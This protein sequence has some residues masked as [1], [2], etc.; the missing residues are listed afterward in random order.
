MPNTN[1]HRYIKDFLDASIT[2]YIETSSVFETEKISKLFELHLNNLTDEELINYLLYSIYIPDEY[3]HDSSEET[4]FSKL[5]EVLVS[6]FFNRL[7]VESIYITTKSG[8]EDVTLFFAPGQNDA[9][10]T[11]VK[12]FRLGRSQKAPNVKDFVKPSDFETEWATKHKSSIGGLIVFPK[13][14]EWTKNSQVYAYCSNP[15]FPILM[16]SYTHLVLLLKFKQNYS[17]EDLKSLWDYTYFE[18]PSSKT[19]EQ[20]W[21]SVD[22]KLQQ[23]F[24]ISSKKY[25]EELQTYEDLITS[26]IHEVVQEYSEN[27]SNH[28]QQIKETAEQWGYEELKNAYIKAQTELD[29]TS[30]KKAINNINKHRLSKK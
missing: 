19:K 18:N 12:T 7:G 11:D 5:I 1:F 2:D 20:Y 17:I 3:S 23:L 4:L 13:S 16:L 10:V 27:I 30:I 29:T 6:S 14:H 26:N 8:R 28:A 24:K 9:V 22:L 25:F 21:K 15:N